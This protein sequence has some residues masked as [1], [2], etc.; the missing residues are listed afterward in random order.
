MGAIII[1]DG[2][3]ALLL[4]EVEVVKAVELMSGE[5]SQVWI[6]NDE[7]STYSTF[8]S[9][10][11]A[12]PL[13]IPVPLDWFFDVLNLAQCAGARIFLGAEVFVINL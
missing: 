7:S 12:Y 13:Q 1:A 10:D 3:D 9:H 8:A 5:D 11:C 2:A 4:A 6:S